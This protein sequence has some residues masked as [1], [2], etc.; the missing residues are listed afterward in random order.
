[1]SLVATFCLLTI[2]AL[3]HGYFWTDAVNRLH[4]WSGPRKVIERLS[5]GCFLAFLVLPLI[6]VMRWNDIV[7]F[8]D[9]ERDN[10]DALS[11][12]VLFCSFWGTYALVRNGLYSYVT[13]NPRLLID[14]QQET[15]DKGGRD[16]SDVFHG[17][18]PKLLSKVPCNQILQLTVDRK[19][20]AIPRLSSAHEGLTLAHISD[21]HMTGRIDRR[22][23]E[24]VVEQVNK[25][26]ADA[27]F[28]TGDIVEKIECWPWLA[29]TLGRL[30]AECGV[31]FVLGNHDY[32]IDV[33][34]T[35]LLLQEHGLVCLSGSTHTTEWKGAAV[36]MAGNEL[37][38]GPAA[39]EASLRRTH[40][41]QE[42][43]LRL[44]LLHSPDQF[45]WACEHD[46]HLALAGH[47]HGG[48]LRFPL[49]GPIVSPSHRGTRYAC[50]VFQREKTV[51][52]VSRGIAGKTPL[53][54]NCPPEIA[55]LELTRA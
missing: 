33:E 52:H 49:L 3:G 45:A 25:L 10:L 24:F 48:Q 26:N 7:V 41:D 53:R 8:Q 14:W 54:W 22:W 23:Y 55:L 47:T 36:E 11:W 16:F 20:L 37:P 42:L 2:A 17:W 1:M 9:S 6:L 40:S 34:Q 12:Y 18:F 50:G 21:L 28:I 38:W 29:E 51:L 30:R 39:T 13:D 19:Q 4:A 5:L 15:V 31:Y 35:K 27:V 43:P 32:Y 46:A 44:M